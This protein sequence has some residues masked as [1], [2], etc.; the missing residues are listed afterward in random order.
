MIIFE[1]NPRR[2][3]IDVYEDD[4]RVGRIECEMGRNPLFLPSEAN[5]PWLTI[6]E[7]EVILKKMREVEAGMRGCV[8][9]G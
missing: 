4:V 1:K 6:S 9:G 2:A 3:N 5:T 8:H 7:L